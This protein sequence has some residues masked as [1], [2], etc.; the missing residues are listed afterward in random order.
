[1]VLAGNTP[2][3]DSIHD[4]LQTLQR[5][6]YKKLSIVCSI[7]V[8]SLSYLTTQYCLDYLLEPPDM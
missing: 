2:S 1:M 7:L 4:I 8:N 3:D 6:I 5:Q